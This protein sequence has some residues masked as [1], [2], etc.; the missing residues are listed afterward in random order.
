M[1]LAAGSPAAAQQRP[2]ISGFQPLFRPAVAAPKTTHY[3]RSE[4]LAPAGGEEVDPEVTQAPP[5]GRPKKEEEFEAPTYT[6]TPGMQRL[7]RRESEEEWKDRMRQEERRRPGAD[8]VEFPTEPAPVKD[9]YA[10]RMFPPAG[11]VAEPCYVP[12][13]RIIFEQPNFERLGYDCGFFQPAV[14]MGVFCFDILILPYQ[15]CKRPFQQFDA[16]AGKPLPGDPA[17]M[18]L[19]PL[20][21]NL[22]GLIGEAAAITGVVLA[23][24]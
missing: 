9:A 7:F 6:D 22:L 23:F 14:S 18:V 21:P 19:D 17:A 5:F 15:Y 20:E 4:P 2:R 11:V 10:P 12:H 1:G 13:R 16:S 8:K 3:F 24:P